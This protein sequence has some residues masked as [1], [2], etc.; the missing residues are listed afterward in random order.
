MITNLSTVIKRMSSP[1]FLDHEESKH[2]YLK[3]LSKKLKNYKNIYK[4]FAF[5]QQDMYFKWSN[6]NIF[7]PFPLFKKCNVIAIF[8]NLFLYLK[9]VTLLQ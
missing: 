3:N 2:G 4:T 6:C 7:E 5:H 9:N 1:T 8:L